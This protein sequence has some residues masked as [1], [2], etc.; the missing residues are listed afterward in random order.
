MG[1][2]QTGI[3]ALLLMS[4]SAPAWALNA[5]TELKKLMHEQY[6]PYSA[7]ARGWPF[8]LNGTSYLMKVLQSKKVAT[9]RGERLY[10][11]TAGDVVKGGSHVDSGM[12]G[13]FVLEEKDG[14]VI[15][16]SGS[17]AMPYGSFGDAP[18]TVKLVQFGPDHYY[19]WL[20][21][22]GY[23]GNG[24]TSSYSD[25]LLPKG[26]TVAA[27]ASIPAHMD[28]D[29][30]YPCDDKATRA[31]CESL[32]F[33]LKLDTA[34]GRVKVYPLVVTRTGVQKG[35]QTKPETWRVE[36]DEGKWQYKVPAALKVQY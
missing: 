31:Q 7:A 20:Y 35:Q 4:S 21:E 29:G 16:T 3:V 28:K 24:F 19:G 15:L 12:A 30:V 32:D 27:M 10:V 25:I 22:S 14:R 17:R 18:D 6:G 9:P 33:D 13:A 5:A 11:F 36:F 8:H 1:R 23:T 34:K 26:G 2:L